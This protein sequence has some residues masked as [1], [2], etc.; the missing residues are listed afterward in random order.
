MRITLIV[1]LFPMTQ[2]SLGNF[3]GRVGNAAALHL[4][5]SSLLP[6][7]TPSL[8]TC[9]A[10]RSSRVLIFDVSYGGSVV[11]NPK[12]RQRFTK[13]TSIETSPNQNRRDTAVFRIL[14]VLWGWR[15]GETQRSSSKP[16]CL[17]FPLAHQPIIIILFL[18][19]R[20]ASTNKCT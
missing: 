4:E 16:A 20:P 5:A 17:C 18:C 3:I 10:V 2:S 15:R 11:C 7:S 6:R 1:I 8:Q 12:Q 13:S 19:C 9:S 14:W